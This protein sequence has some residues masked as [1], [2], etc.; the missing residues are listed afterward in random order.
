MNIKIGYMKILFDLDGTISD[1]KDGIVKSINYALTKMNLNKYEGRVLEKYI[2]PSLKITFDD[3]LPNPTEEDIS[4]AIILFRERYFDVGWKEN[5]VYEGIEE[6]LQD[7]FNRD[8]QLY[9]CTSKR[10]DIAIRIIKN[11]GLFK[12]F[13]S[14]RGCDIDK[15]KGQLINEMISHDKEN[16]DNI[17]MVGDRHYDVIAAKE[18]SIGSIGVLWGYG[19]RNELKNAGA[20]IILD[21]VPMLRDCQLT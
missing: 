15:T 14:I 9:V 18:N 19:T 10:E 17:W 1:P 21:T 5:V 8:Y 12:Y 6:I 13:I 20:D 16:G 4:Q 3:L 7:F 11:F 2:G